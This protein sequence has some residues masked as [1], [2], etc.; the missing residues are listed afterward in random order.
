VSHPT[1]FVQYAGVEALKGDQ[2]PVY[3]M[4]AEFRMRRDLVLDELSKIGIECR[5]PNGAFYSFINI[6]K[7]GSS[8]EV[9]ERLLR[10]AYVAVTPGLAFGP[11]GERYLRLSYATSRDRIV[12]GIKRIGEVLLS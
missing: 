9:T 12:E 8:I 2:Q 10:D 5:K 1:S 6:S 7:F 3:D 11:S 4:T